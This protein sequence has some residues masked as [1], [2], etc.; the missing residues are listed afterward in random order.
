MAV[1]SYSVPKE[2]SHYRVEYCC[3]AEEVQSDRSNDADLLPF[4]QIVAYHGEIAVDPASGTILRLM[5]EAEMKAS[6]PV[7]RASIVV[8]YG[9]VEIRSEEHTSELQSLRHLVCR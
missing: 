7:A 3:V 8:E 6:D 4:S 1:F 5:L 9:P 2:K